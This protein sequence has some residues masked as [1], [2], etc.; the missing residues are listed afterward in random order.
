MRSV[1]EPQA[2]FVS[3]FLGLTYQLGAALGIAAATVSVQLLGSPRL[4]SALSNEGVA[5]DAL[6]RAGLTDAFLH[7]L[8]TTMAIGAALVA[9]GAVLALGLIGRAPMRPSSQALQDA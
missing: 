4:E 3:G 5:P 1:G 9:V 7:A 2:G 8:T 6:R